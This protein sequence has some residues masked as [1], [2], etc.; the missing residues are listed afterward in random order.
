MKDENKMQHV[1]AL[2]R[3]SNTSVGSDPIVAID[4]TQSWKAETGIYLPTICKIKPLKLCQKTLNSTTEHVLKDTGCKKVNVNAVGPVLY[5]A[6]HGWHKWT[7]LPW[8]CHPRMDTSGMHCNVNP[9]ITVQTQLYNELHRSTHSYR[10]NTDL[11]TARFDKK[12]R[13]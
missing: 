1:F 6:S 10:A 2:N 9:P 11:R 8:L 5:K 12:N 4:L 13:M 3:R 7:F